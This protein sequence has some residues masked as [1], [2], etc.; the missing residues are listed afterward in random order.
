MP[1]QIIS[2]GK[3]SPGSDPDAGIRNLISALASSRSASASGQTAQLARDK[4][5]KELIDEEAKLKAL[6]EF[7][8]NLPKQSSEKTALESGEG[9]DFFDKLRQVTNPSTRVVSPNKDEDKDVTERKQA[10]STTV[11]KAIPDSDFD[12]LMSPEDEARLK[13]LRAE[14]TVDD[15]IIEENIPGSVSG[16]G[17]RQG[18]FSTT[19]PAVVSNQ[20][21]LTVEDVS[22]KERNPDFD[23]GVDKGLPSIIDKKSGATFPKGLSLPTERRTPILNALANIS[24][25]GVNELLKDKTFGPVIQAALND[26]PLSAQIFEKLVE[27]AT[28]T[29]DHGKVMKDGNGN[30]LM[31]DLSGE[32]PRAV[33][34]NTGIGAVVSGLKK[35]EVGEKYWNFLLT[36]GGLTLAELQSGVDK[37]GNRIDKKSL[38]KGFNKW[39]IDKDFTRTQ[40]A[41]ENSKLYLK[42]QELKDVNSIL[43]STKN[44]FSVAF[45]KTMAKTV[46]D[47]ALVTMFNKLTDPQSVVREG[48]FE[49]IFAAR[50]LSGTVQTFIDKIK[51]FRK[52]GSLLNDNERD[53]IKEFG[54]R[55]MVNQ[56]A[57]GGLSDIIEIVDNNMDALGLNKDQAIP[58][59]MRER[60]SEANEIQMRLPAFGND[61]LQAAKVTRERRKK[62]RRKSKRSRK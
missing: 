59:S 21:D 45:S 54:L 31:M 32:V 19:G 16:A 60:I 11:P 37:S 22:F 12:G 10:I 47:Q 55:A 38:G 17:Q 56:L 43:N 34:V 57:D 18:P 62:L 23:V 8:K 3:G 41:L 26:K 15:T 61:I 7:I 6:P 2:L 46:G 35:S 27:N 25:R 39:M 14:D 29:G 49:R 20:N 13:E 28:A 58:P 48:E 36:K 50:N 9:V 30:F 42:S 53:A 24:P 51:N 5:N 40:M 44:I 1:R 4:F 33:K 52:G